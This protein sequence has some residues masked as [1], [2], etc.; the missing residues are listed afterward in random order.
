L[1]ASRLEVLGVSGYLS[2]CHA[3]EKFFFTA[4]SDSNKR[5]NQAMQRTAGRSAFPVL[6]DY[7][8]L[9]AT[10]LAFASGR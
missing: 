4:M 9:L 7:Y 5:S 6:D 2:A 10:T 3:S 1:A 8:L